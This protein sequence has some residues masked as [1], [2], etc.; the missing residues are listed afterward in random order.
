MPKLEKS[1]KEKARQHTIYKNKDGKRIPGVTTILGVMDKPAL[2]HWANKIGLEGI[3]M[4]KYVDDLAVIGTLAHLIIEKYIKDEK[5]CYDDYTANQIK[6]AENS[7]LKFFVWLE[8]KD[9]KLLGSEMRLVSEKH[10]YGGT[11]DIYAKV[12][13]IKTLIDIKTCKAIYPEQFTQVSGYKSLLEENSYEVEDSVILRVGRDESEGFEY[14][15][16]PRIDAH[17][18]RF[19][20]CKDL[21]DINKELNRIKRS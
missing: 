10:Q 13:N 17:L 20:I 21:Y 2:K 18:R 1:S 6:A 14:H 4:S 7:V 15:H 8:G 16:V 9:F 19:L 11:V 3:E 12:N 5:M